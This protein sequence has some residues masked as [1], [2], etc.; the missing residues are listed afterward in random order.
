L[1]FIVVYQAFDLQSADTATAVNNEACS[2]Y[3]LYKRG[4]ARV[5]FELAWNVLNKVLGHRHP[6]TVTV[7]RNLDKARRSQATLSHTDLRQ[8]F[9]MRPDADMLLV[10]GNFTIQAVNSGGFGSGKKVKGRGISGDKGKRKGK[11]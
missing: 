5:R 8:S 7:W 6:R 2:L 9:Q 3:G 4:E 10:G 1:T 11:K